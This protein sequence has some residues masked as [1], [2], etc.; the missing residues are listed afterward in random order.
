MTDKYT[1]PLPAMTGLTREY[2]DGCARGELRFQRC[3]HCGT[4]RHVP[5]EICAACSSFDWEWVASSGRGTVY[6]WTVVVRALHPDFVGDTPYAPVVVEMEE[7]VR[8]VSQV[9]DCPPDQLRVGLPVQ[10]KFVAVSDQVTL[11]YFCRA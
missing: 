1:K 8:V 7:G 9:L 6:T 11:P 10:V 4:F 2:Y 3:T 5:R